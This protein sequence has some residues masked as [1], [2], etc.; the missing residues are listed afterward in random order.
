MENIVGK[1]I[2][3]LLKIKGHTPMQL[4]QKLGVTKSTISNWTRGHTSVPLKYI[5]AI[6]ELYPGLN[7]EYLLFDRGSPFEGHDLQD[8]QPQHN[9]TDHTHNDLLVETRLL[10][11]EIKKKDNRIEQLN[12]QIGYCKK[13]NS[14]P[15][16]TTDL[17]EKNR[18]NQQKEIA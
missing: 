15:N 18:K 3:K 4:A 5:Y 9:E 11:E 13:Q 17:F 6:I 10:R 12:R 16:S 2:G 7:I 14:K 8:S 1:Q